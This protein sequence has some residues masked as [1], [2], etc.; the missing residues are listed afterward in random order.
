MWGAFLGGVIGMA[1]DVFS[2][3]YAAVLT[4]RK[5]RA[6]ARP[7]GFL[8]Q[9]S[10]LETSFLCLYE[11]CGEFTPAR[12][13][14][15]LAG[16]H[17]NKVAEIYTRQKETRHPEGLLL[18]HVVAGHNKELG[19]VALREA[20]RDMIRG[21][22]GVNVNV[23]TSARKSVEAHLVDMYKFI[24]TRSLAVPPIR[25][26]KRHV[27]PAKKIAVAAVEVAT[28]DD[29]RVHGRPVLRAT[30]A[31]GRVPAEVVPAP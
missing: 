1:K 19:I 17:L 30:A 9:V 18:A 24:H 23:V 21:N 4:D 22:P 3:E 27:G 8:Y 16:R 28:D 6:L 5:E 15:D 26:N 7:H 2:S 25:G 31:A 14:L 10:D 12:V 11:S 13:K 29:D 20:T